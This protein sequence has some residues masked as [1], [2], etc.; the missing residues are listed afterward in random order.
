MIT[1]K[2]PSSTDH[3]HALG[4]CVITAWELA[5]KFG[6]LRPVASVI[7]V[8]GAVDHE[9]KFPL[10]G[11]S[12]LRTGQRHQKLNQLEKRRSVQSVVE[13]NRLLLVHKAGITISCKIQDDL[14]CLMT[15]NC[16]VNDNC[17]VNENCDRWVELRPMAA[18]NTRV[19]A[20]FFPKIP[21][22]L[23]PPM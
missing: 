18:E 3:V 17:D 1:K 9:R 10:G 4:Y 20:R 11:E 19:R 12:A 13:S 7:A 6:H 8:R 2:R 16:D 22:G 23:L 21:M 14:K 5:G 15:L